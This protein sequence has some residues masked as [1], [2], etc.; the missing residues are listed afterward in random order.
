MDFLE[1][2]LIGFAMYDKSICFSI[3]TVCVCTR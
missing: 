3:G 1:F 2:L